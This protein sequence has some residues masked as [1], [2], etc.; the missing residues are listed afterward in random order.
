[1]EGCPGRDCWCQ[2][3]W[4][5]IHAGVAR[6]FPGGAVDHIDPY[7]YVLPF[8]VRERFSEPDVDGRLGLVEFVGVHPVMLSCQYRALRKA[9]RQANWGILSTRIKGGV[10][11][12]IE[13]CRKHKHA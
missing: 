6:V 12:T 5:C 9:M 2:L 13:I 1:M 7:C 8:V 10:S 4:F 3:D 11:R